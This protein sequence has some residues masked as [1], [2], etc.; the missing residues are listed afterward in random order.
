MFDDL[1]WAIKSKLST[2]QND[3]GQVTIWTAKALKLDFY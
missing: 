1:D 2:L 3:G